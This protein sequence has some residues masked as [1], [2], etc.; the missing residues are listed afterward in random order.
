M[1]GRAGY[2]QFAHWRPWRIAA[3]GGLSPGALSRCVATA[4]LCGSKLARDSLANRSVESRREATTCAVSSDVSTAVPNGPRSRCSREV[5]Y[6][7]IRRWFVP[8][9]ARPRRSISNSHGAMPRKNVCPA[10]PRGR[11]RRIHHQGRPL[12]PHATG[13]LAP[14]RAFDRRKTIRKSRCGGSVVSRPQNATSSELYR[15]QQPTDAA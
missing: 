15:S 11:P 2:G 1:P 8:A 3:W 10:P 12:R 5:G 13:T 14:Y 9:R 6:P 4:T 7:S